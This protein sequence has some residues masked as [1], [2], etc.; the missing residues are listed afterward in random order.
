MSKIKERLR[1]LYG[2]QCEEIYPAVLALI[3]KWN[4]QIQQNYPWVGKD[5][6]MMITYGDGIRQKGKTPLQALKLFMDEEMEHTVSAVHLLPMFPYTSDDGFSVRDFRKI[7]PEL[8][9]WEDI[10]RLQEDYDLMFDAVINHVSKSSVYFQEFLKGNDTYRNYFIAADPDGDYSKV[11]RPRALPLLTAFETA[12]GTCSVW[13]TFSEDQIDFN[14][15]EP[16]VLLEILD[17]LLFY[18]SKGARFLRF[19]AIG[20]AWKEEDSTCMHLPQTHELVK[21]MRE[22][23]EACVQGC[24]I[25]TETNVPHRDNISYFG[26]GTDEAG[27]VYQF[28]LP[29]LTL[30]SYISGNTE[31][32]SAWAESLEPTAPQTTYFNFLSSHDGIGMRPAE[33]ILT[34]EE[35]QRM[36]DVTLERGGQIG[37]RI[38]PDGTEAPYELNINYLDAIAGDEQDEEI[39]AQKFMGAQCI[40]LSL[41]GMPGIY[42]HSL[43]GSRN[44]YQDYEESKI[45][46]RINREKLDLDQL[47][48]EL[49]QDTLRSKVLNCYKALL[50][51]RKTQDAFTPNRSQRVVNYDPR[52]FAVIRGD[53]EPVLVLVNVS[54]DCVTIQTGYHGT[55][56]LTGAVVDDRVEM[57][58]YA[59]L[60][61]KLKNQERGMYF[62]KKKYAETPIYSYEEVKER[63]PIPVVE[64]K[65]Q[66][67]KTYNYAMEILFKNIHKP[68]DG[69]GFVSNFVDAAFN[70]D[71]FLWDT[72]FIT[73]FCNL[74]HPYVPGICSL[75][76]FYCKQ[77]DDGEISREMVRETGEDFPLWVN[78]Y[79]KPLYSYFHNHYGFRR[80]KEMTNL[81]YEEMYKPDLGR[82]VERNPYLTLDNLNHP[83]L[84]LGEIESYRRTGDIE[85]LMMVMEPLYRQYEAFKYHLRHV[86]GLYVT[87]WASMDNSP[88]NQYLGMGVDITSEM[89]LFAKQL[90]E[91]LDILKEKGYEVEEAE[92]RREMLTDDRCKTIQA[93][94]RYMWNEADGFYYDVDF[95]GRQ[96][97]IKTIAGFAPMLAGASDRAQMDRLVY[98]LNDKDTF[99]RIHRIPVLAANEP[100]FDPEGG[101][102]SGSVWA[103]TNVMVLLGLEENGYH[104]LARE[105]GLN[106]MQIMAQVFEK[107]GT[108]WENYPA[109]SITSGNADNADFVG[110]SGVG[111]ILYLIEYGIGLH[112]DIHGVAWEIDEKLTDGKLG[113]EN[114]WFAG[115]TADF[116]AQ[117][118]EGKLGIKVETNDCFNL[119]IRYNK[120]EFYFEVTGNLEVLLDEAN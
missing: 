20:F 104:D 87:D 105:I 32:L 109:D 42:Y 57:K 47:R 61:I 12:D 82:K 80:L 113:C 27:L 22:V 15:K 93:I 91:I 77:F 81:S 102:W 66:W 116:S 74:L 2:E 90:L 23:V 5:D 35:R 88:R 70:A 10:E 40:L 25:I 14:Y 17:I 107:T 115:K 108:I 76:N 50:K 1:F 44:C 97:G 118:K 55:E 29:P 103:P 100:G 43:L 13:T 30:H 83:V 3:E 19:D 58:P 64:A 63:L 9:T 28:P 41:M 33:D 84:A 75:D 69:S 120:R 79:Q 65:P 67:K 4:H 62:S 85:R 18:A 7:N 56:L 37:Y 112:G 34:A 60:W 16:K 106:H 68:V 21:L 110:W 24:T 94:N 51:I 26:D 45:K 114:F 78:T 54:S 52:V 49:R 92:I 31:K 39:M 46:R 48:E 111:A 101:Y 71:I 8:G 99:N 96:T 86:T 6:V 72:V 38:L 59:Y 11:T 95:E 117:K 73:F 119:R 89:V 36:V 98:W 53:E